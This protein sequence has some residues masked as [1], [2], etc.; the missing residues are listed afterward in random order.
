MNNII[1]CPH[2]G[3]SY[4]QQLY[5]T[6]TCLGWIPV[7]KNGKLINKDPNKTTVTCHCLECEEDFSYEE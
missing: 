1:N 5:K 4:Y 3:K 2:C 6:S 7:Y